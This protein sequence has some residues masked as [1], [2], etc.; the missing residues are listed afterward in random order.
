M[1]HLP[2]G[3]FR[4]TGQQLNEFRPGGLLFHRRVPVP[5][6]FAVLQPIALARVWLQQF[7]ELLEPVVKGEVSLVLILKDLTSLAGIDPLPLLVAED[8]DQ[9]QLSPLELP[10]ELPRDPPGFVLNEVLD[11]PALPE[12]ECIDP[13][14]KPAGVDQ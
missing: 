14:L 12:S 3:P 6:L 5:E 7:T 4:G 2:I 10:S 11:N 9:T 1:G 8:A 13:I